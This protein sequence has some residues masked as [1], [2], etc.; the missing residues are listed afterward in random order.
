M[1]QSKKKFDEIKFSPAIIQWRIW[2]YFND[3]DDDDD[4]FLSIF[5]TC[6]MNFVI[7]E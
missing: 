6:N 4:R 1:Y 2:Y 3:D 7:N 5:Y